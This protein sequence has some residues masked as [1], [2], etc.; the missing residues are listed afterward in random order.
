MLLYGGVELLFPDQDGELSKWLREHQNVEDIV[1]LAE[2]RL[3][4]ISPRRG[5]QSW[6]GV[7]K[8]IGQTVANY[9]KAPKPRLNTLY[10]PTGATRW[11][12]G[13]FLATG[14]AK[15]QIVAQAHSPGRNTPL[16]LKM[17]EDSSYLETAMYLLPPRIVARPIPEPGQQDESLWILPL[18][19]VRYWWQNRSTDD[20]EVTTSTTWTNLFS[21]LGTKL[22]VTISV[23]TAVAAAY[24]QPDPIE[25]TRRYENAASMLDAAALSVGKRI[26]RRIDGTVR[27]ESPADALAAFEA[28]FNGDWQQV[29][30]GG[31]ENPGGSAPAAVITTFRRW[32]DYAILQKGKVHAESSNAPAEV[33]VVAGTRKQIHS[34]AFADYTASDASASN[35]ASLAALATKIGD[36]FFS[37]LY[38]TH[39]Y[40]FSGIKPWHPTGFDDAVEWTFG[41]Q[42]HSGKYQAQTRIQSLP[43]DFGFDLQ[44]SQFSNRGLFEPIM[45]GKADAA[46]VKG[47]SGTVS[48]WEGRAG[49][50]ADLGKNITACAEVAPIQKGEWVFAEWIED[51]WELSRVSGDVLAIATLQYP[52]CGNT[53]TIV[54]FK[55]L[56]GA[57]TPAPLPTTADNTLFKH[58]G[59]AGD[60]VLLAWS[61]ILNDADEPTGWIVI[62]VTGHDHGVYVGMRRTGNCESFCLEADVIQARLEICST[63]VS[64]VIFCY[65]CNDS[66]LQTSI[67]QT[68]FAQTSNLQTSTVGCGAGIITPEL[69]EAGALIIST[70]TTPEDSVRQVRVTITNQAGCGHDV[71]T[72]GDWDVLTPRNN[73]VYQAF[74]EPNGYEAIVANLSAYDP[75]SLSYQQG[76][77]ETYQ[78]YC[79]QRTNILTGGA[80]SADPSDVEWVLEGRYG[81]PTLGLGIGGSSIRISETQGGAVDVL[82]G[83]TWVTMPGTLQIL[84][85]NPFH[86]Q[87]IFTPPGWY[88]TSLEN[89]TCGPVMVEFEEVV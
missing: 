59:L 14:A 53:A 38:R 88:P 41:N 83:G 65:P 86:A 49:A 51:D 15:D 89:T 18:V 61:S 78:L 84:S 6:Y 48:I 7:R 58:R 71:G 52:L 68:S 35:S 2:P 16:K 32:R 75:G 55:R 12:R 80:L 82:D 62:D 79:R 57:D 30:G 81:V 17:G 19:D 44:L 4:E 69:L 42:G 60:K 67:E 63:H 72:P 87:A 37:W 39:D 46:I 56:D 9:P 5:L 29:C 8:G 28:N 11:A 77:F 25:F 47:A 64:H 54:D 1:A 33:S 34:T 24:L 36:D 13:Y 45:L 76:F 21:T 70:G 23:P 74:T 3:A 31:I 50:K 27:A 73:S 43:H 40:T 26:V 20:L 66:S 85:L 22:G 10:W